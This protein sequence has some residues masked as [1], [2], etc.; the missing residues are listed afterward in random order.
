MENI[1]SRDYQQI[2]K[3]GSM[4]GLIDFSIKTMNRQRKLSHRFHIVFLFKILMRN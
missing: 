2:R 1:R 4:G 3:N